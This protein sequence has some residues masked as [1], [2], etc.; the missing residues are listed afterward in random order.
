M[1]SVALNLGG[2]PA[3]VGLRGRVLVGTD[4]TWDGAAFDGR[5]GPAEGVVLAELHE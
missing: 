1:A 2:R 3:Q 5:L 4:R